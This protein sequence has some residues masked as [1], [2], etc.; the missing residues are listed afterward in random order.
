[1][2][3]LPLGGT[4]SIEPN[5][6][7]LILEKSALNVILSE[8]NFIK[9]FFVG[10]VVNNS[11]KEGSVVYIDFDTILSAFLNLI[12]HDT[13]NLDNLLILRPNSEDVGKIMAHACS[14]F[15]PYIKL[16]ILDSITTLYY[17]L[18]SK[19][20]SDVN[21]KIG[22]YLGLFQSLAERFDIPII[23]TSMIRAKRVKKAEL[24]LTSP[25][26]GRALLKARI[27]LKLNKISDHI[28]INI[29]KHENKAF[30]NKSFKLPI[31]L[32]EL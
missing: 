28:E 29:I 21:R 3:R 27:V 8:D 23:V 6:C 15:S 20:P 19:A 11:L 31:K 10:N 32:S 12:I 16:I 4:I 17:L 25:T 9:T 30:I 13:K 1:M 5:D 22:V 24:W 18:D 2:E 7:S 14:F 26:G